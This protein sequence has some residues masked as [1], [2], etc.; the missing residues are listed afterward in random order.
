VAW[1]ATFRTAAPGALAALKQ[2]LAA[3]AGSLDEFLATEME[4]QVGRLTSPEFIEGRDAFFERRPP[5]FAN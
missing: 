4:T 1:A 3:G 5:D 2:L